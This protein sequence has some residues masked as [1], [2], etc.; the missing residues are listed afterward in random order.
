MFAGD[1]IERHE[2]HIV[3][4]AGIGLADIA[5]ANEEEHGARLQSV[6]VYARHSARKREALFLAFGR[7]LGT[8]G[9]CGRCRGRCSAGFPLGL[10][11]RS[12]GSRTRLFRDNQRGRYRRDREIAFALRR[13]ATV[14]QGKRGEVQ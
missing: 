10:W 13:P 3:A 6:V 8:G 11:R 12:R 2:A 9:R 7:S 5:E 14:R 4:M 1:G